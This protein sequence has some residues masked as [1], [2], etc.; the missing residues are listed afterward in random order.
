MDQCILSPSHKSTIPQSVHLTTHHSPHC[1][2]SFTLIYEL[3]KPMQAILQKWQSMHTWISINLCLLCKKETVA[4]QFVVLYVHEQSSCRNKCWQYMLQHRNAE[5]LHIFLWCHFMLWQCCAYGLVRF[6]HKLHLVRRRKG[7][8]FG[9]KYLFCH[10]EHNWK[11]S[12]VLLN[13]NHWLGR[14]CF[15]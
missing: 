10:Q 6:G 7:S 15:V 2:F 8:C 11:L 12:W 3:S 1:L 13:Y 14:C 5:K 9:L 4:F